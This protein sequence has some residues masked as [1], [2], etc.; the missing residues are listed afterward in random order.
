MQR[1]SSGIIIYY[2]PSEEYVHIPKTVIRLGLVQWQMR[3]TPSLKAMQEQIEF[4]ID[5]V[6]GYQV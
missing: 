6:S 5:V 4:F 1:L 3:P 2:E